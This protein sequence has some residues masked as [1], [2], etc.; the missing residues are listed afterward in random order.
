MGGTPTV[1]DSLRPLRHRQFSLEDVE[2]HH[3]EWPEK[4]IAK[5]ESGAPGHMPRPIQVDTSEPG[6]E[7]ISTAFCRVTRGYK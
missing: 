3:P 7:N 6:L 1:N 5:I 4:W 2:D